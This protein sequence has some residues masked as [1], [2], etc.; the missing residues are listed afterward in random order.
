MSEQ[1][2]TLWEYTA[3]ALRREFE[4][5]G[6]AEPDVFLVTLYYTLPPGEDPRTATLEVQFNSER[7]WA[8]H[9]RRRPG[10]QAGSRWD[11]IWLAREAVL[12]D[13]DRDPEGHAALVR[14]ALDCGL[15][16]FDDPDPDENLVIEESM[17]LDELMTRGL[18]ATIRDLH[19][20]GAVRAAFGRDIPVTLVPQDSHDP[21]PEWNREANP[22]ELYALFGPFYESIWSPG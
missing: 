13:P 6:A 18:I 12:W 21:Y 17:E 20:S 1:P 5:I 19:A 14:W 15:R 3:R 9:V 8:E 4:R 16:H 22:P 7:H 11:Y 10:E 2:P